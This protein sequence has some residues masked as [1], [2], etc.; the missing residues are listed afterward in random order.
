MKPP[1]I[2]RTRELRQ[3]ELDF[4]HLP[5]ME[6]AGLAGAEIARQ[7]IGDAGAR[8]LVLAGPRNNGGDA[9]V[10]ARWLREWFFDVTLAYR[11][12]AAQLSTDAAAAYAAWIAAGGSAVGEIPPGWRGALI[13]DGLF[14]IGLARPLDGD[15][16]RWVEWANAAGAPILALDVP[17]GLDADTGRV[18]G[19]CIR[20]ARTASFI[21]LKP[22]LVTADGPDHCGEVAVLDLG[23]DL[24]AQAG[25]GELVRWPDLACSL[26]DVLSRRR[27]NVH[28]GSFGTL[29]IIGGGDGMV[30]AAL[31]AGRAAL[32][33]GAGKTLVGLTA[34]EAPRVDPTAPELMLRTAEA[35]LDAAVD[36]LVCGPG[37][38]TG[39]TAR[40]WVRRALA[41]RAPLLLD[42]DAL[43]VL[44]ADP[45][46]VALTRSRD[47][48]TLLSPHPGEA[49]RLLG[50]SGTAVQG[51]RL[52]A[53]TTLAA[54]L[55]AAVA[56]KG[57]GTVIAAPDGGWQINASGNA[58]LAS[59]GTGDTL[60]GF[61]GALLAQGIAG[62]DALR[63]AV[64]LHGAAA[65][66]LVA[67]GEGPLG[68][69]AGEL[70]AAARALLNAAAT[71]TRAAAV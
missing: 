42:A 64:C 63:L 12:D 23:L 30:G 19:P 13:V 45:A 32:F 9:F 65:D 59:G 68:L 28:K 40:E 38:G 53:A 35:V 43:N 44:A 50:I 1:A 66:A 48:A 67:A 5:L 36:A 58:G 70:P 8:V 69:T 16:A 34:A 11:G 29:G 55:N 31:L 54:T 61:V 14:G 49:A 52:A 37:L 6:R 33:T 27:R 18:A 3:I 71:R 7:M 41:V 4:A 25:G 62:V 21:A 46:L 24:G 10:V 15:Y 26:P 39:D 22:G 17:S 60:S 51:D 57:V 56:L 2:Y 20:A 47:H